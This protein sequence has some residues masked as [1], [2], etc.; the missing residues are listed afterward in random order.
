MNFRTIIN[1]FCNLGN[2]LRSYFKYP[3]YYSL[4][5]VFDMRYDFYNRRYPELHTSAE[6]GFY[7]NIRWVYLFVFTT[8]LDQMWFK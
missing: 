7:N 6:K 2:R 5:E 4:S 3:E 1:A 8:K